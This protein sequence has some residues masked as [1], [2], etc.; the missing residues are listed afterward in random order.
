MM[1]GVEE[2][3]VLVAAAHAA[4]LLGHTTGMD[5]ARAGASFKGGP[6]PLGERRMI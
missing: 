3:R 5:W 4:T 1:V 2:A 6:G